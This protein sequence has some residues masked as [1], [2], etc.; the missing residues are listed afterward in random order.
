MS[1]KLKQLGELINKLEDLVMEDTSNK[2]LVK[3]NESLKQE[4]A[5]LKETSQEVINELNNSIQII[6]DYFK[7]QN[8][9]SKNT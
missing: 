9:N 8:A 1:I 6:E 5:S 7:K 4:Y 2:Q 3:E